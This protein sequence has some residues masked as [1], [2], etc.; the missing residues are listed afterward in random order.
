[1]SI[2]TSKRKAIE[3]WENE[4]GELLARDVW[5]SGSKEIASPS[6]S[7]EPFQIAIV[8]KMTNRKVNTLKFENQ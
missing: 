1:M 7:L 6:G 2:D 3:R 5:A 8:N 4:G